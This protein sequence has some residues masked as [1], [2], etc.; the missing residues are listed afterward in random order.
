MS[1]IY[2]IWVC[3]ELYTGHTYTAVGSYILVSVAQYHSMHVDI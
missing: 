3:I 2:H 1:S